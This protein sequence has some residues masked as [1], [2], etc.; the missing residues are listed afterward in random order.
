[1]S[2]LAPFRGR[3]HSVLLT[4]QP[5]RRSPVPFAEFLSVSTYLDI[6]VGANRSRARRNDRISAP[7][8]FAE[9]LR[10]VGGARRVNRRMAAPPRRTISRYA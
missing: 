6:K 7:R 4:C 8:W 2:F 5:I 3:S 9:F 10:D 1:M